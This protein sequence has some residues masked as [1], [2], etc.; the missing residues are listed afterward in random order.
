[1]TTKRWSTLLGLTLACVVGGCS[2]VLAATEPAEGGHTSR[3][4]V[5]LL[6]LALIILAA[7]LGGDLMV[8]LRQPEVLGE[9]VVGIILGNLSLLGITTF[10][11]LPHTPGGLPSRLTSTSAMRSSTTTTSDAPAR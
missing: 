4:I 2:S 7:K 8:R 3:V 6:A 11:F 9:L 5:V 10:D 1:M